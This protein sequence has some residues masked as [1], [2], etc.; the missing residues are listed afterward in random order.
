MCTMYV[1]CV[2]YLHVCYFF[3]LFCP[4]VHPLICVSSVCTYVSLCMSTIYVHCVS[5]RC[6]YTLYICY[7]DILLCIDVLYRPM[8][9]SIGL[10]FLVCM[11]CICTIC[12]KFM[13]IMYVFYLCIRCMCILYTIHIPSFVRLSIP[14]SIC[15][16]FCQPM[17]TI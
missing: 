15:P 13:Y 17:F 6:V 11:L 1:H 5:M 9:L 2:Y 8:L 16:S 7:I 3:L 4:F 14:Q 10:C 12:I